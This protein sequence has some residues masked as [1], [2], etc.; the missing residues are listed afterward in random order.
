MVKNFFLNSPVFTV[1]NNCHLKNFLPFS[2]PDQLSVSKWHPTSYP[3]LQ[4]EH[5]LSSRSRILQYFPSLSMNLPEKKTTIFPMTFNEFA[6]KKNNRNLI[7]IDSGSIR[8]WLWFFFQM[9]LF[10]LKIV[11]FFWY[12]HCWSKSNS[13][14]QPN[15]NDNK[16]NWV[17]FS[18]NLAQWRRN[19]GRSIRRTSSASWTFLDLQESKEYEF[20]ARTLRT[21][22]P[23]LHCIKN[24]P[25]KHFNVETTLPD[26]QI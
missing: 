22:P 9:W 10:C 18:R 19:C 6:W 15:K 3:L 8:R 26:V 2:H 24:V 17:L 23:K 1:P 7:F 25:S 11:R 12:F 16:K 20:F 13:I 5:R 4:K 21:D 14:S